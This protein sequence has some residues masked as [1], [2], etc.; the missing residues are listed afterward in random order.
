MSN[1]INALNICDLGDLGYKRS[2][3]MWSNKREMGV[4]VKEQLDKAV[5]SPKWCGSYPDVVVEG[6]PVSCFD[7]NPLWMQ[8]SPP[9]FSAPRF[10]R[11]EASWDVSP[12]CAKVVKN[13]WG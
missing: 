4:F 9:Y 10:F 6:L 2:K 1:F 3:F 11:F 12:E 5:A 7:N 8:F 13:A